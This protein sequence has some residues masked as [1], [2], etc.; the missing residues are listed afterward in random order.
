MY[1]SART[2]APA[3]SCRSPVSLSEVTAAVKPGHKRVKNSILFIVGMPGPTYLFS[4]RMLPD[5]HIVMQMKYAIICRTSSP[6]LLNRVE[7]GS[8]DGGA[9]TL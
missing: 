1:L 3:S 8:S 5:K 9:L 7:A 4:G 2:M 6:F